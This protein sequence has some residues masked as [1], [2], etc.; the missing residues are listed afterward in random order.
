MLRSLRPEP[1]DVPALFNS[2]TLPLNIRMPDSLFA[3]SRIPSDNWLGFT[4]VT[5]G[6][7][8]STLLL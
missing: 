3:R 2:I 5:F 1:E 4:M 6:G 8:V 7:F